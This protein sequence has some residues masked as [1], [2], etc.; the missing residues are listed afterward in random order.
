MVGEVHLVGAVHRVGRFMRSG[1]PWCGKNHG[2]GVIHGWG[3]PKGGS[4]L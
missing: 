4:Y 3:G 2:V 1:G